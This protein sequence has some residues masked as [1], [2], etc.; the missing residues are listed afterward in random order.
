MEHDGK[1]GFQTGTHPLPSPERL[2]SNGIASLRLSVVIPVYNEESTLAELLNRVLAAPADLE[3]VVVDDGST[4]GTGEILER[5]THEPRV[6]VIR[7]ARNMGKG[8]AIRTAIAH[9]SGDVVL[10]Q[11]ADLEYDPA[12]YEVI[13]ARFTDPEVLVVYGSRRLL[14]SNPMS[15]VL[16]FFGGVTLTWITNVLYGTRITDEPT[17][18]KAF[19][20]EF[21]KELPLVCRRFEFCPEVTALVAKSG[22]RIHEVPIHYYPRRKT[23]GKKIR[24]RDWFQAVGTLLRCRFQRSSGLKEAKRR[25]ASGLS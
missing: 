12:D 11:D 13:L 6:R 3:V 23:E 9:V 20:S 2:P 5:Y 7:H 8:T 10:V 24:A 4:D 1:K 21:L 16:F 19:R 18:Y 14:K 17:C 22:V 15:S 25:R